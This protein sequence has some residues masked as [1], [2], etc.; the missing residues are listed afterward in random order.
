MCTL[1]HNS[2]ESISR[3]FLDF[4]FTKLVWLKISQFLN[5][6]TMWMGTTLH[7]FLENWA[8]MEF[9]L[10]HLPTLVCWF[11][12]LTCNRA[13]FENSFVSLNYVCLRILG[14]L[15]T[16]NIMRTPAPQFI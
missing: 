13:I 6:Q 10:T 14:D 1:C 5:L 2:Y 7:D 4:L 8:L 16:A 15:K 12:W 3:I 11:I 9:S